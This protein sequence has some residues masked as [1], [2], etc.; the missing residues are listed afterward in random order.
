MN[1]RH[2][3]RRLGWGVT[4]QAVSSLSNVLVSLVVAHAL[5]PASFGAFSLAFVT[6]ALVL[7]ASRGLSTDPLLVRFSGAAD[8]RWRQAVAAATATATLV[9]TGCGVLGVAVGL[10]LPGQLGQ[11][12]LALG[13]GLPLLM[14]EDS[15][16]FAFFAVGRGLQALVLD[17]VWT[18][19]AI[20][21][22]A[23]LVVTHTEGVTSCLLVF[24]GS[25]A[26]SAGLGVLL[27]G[28]RP[29]PSLIVA[30]VS[31]HQRLGGRYLVENL[32]VGGSRQLRTMTV[33]G[34]AGLGAVG[35]VRAAEI[36]MGPFLV[37]LMG[38]AQVAVPEASRVVAEA[39][40]RLRAFCL[41]IGGSQAVV[42]LC[43]GLAMMVVLPYGGGRLLLGDLWPSVH[44]LLLP[45]TL[46]VVLG[47]LSSGATSGLRALGASPRS[48]R[49]QLIASA[50]Y[51]A[52]GA[53]GAF[54]GGA[55]GSAW[56]WTAGTL[57]AVA[58]WWHELGRACAEHAPDQDADPSRMLE[59]A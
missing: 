47:C 31:G 25:S 42:A 38:I 4:D 40:R 26:V 58:V 39:P 57:I 43:W 12:F 55:K 50:L 52:G 9:G 27:S 44:P 35:V 30:W 21:G 2:L 48:L 37:V 17:L 11:A 36:L 46:G 41:L 20:G 18:V 24:G 51:V 13:V 56:G 49:A 3:V 23:A 14:L 34:V 7:N 1:F 5:S 8:A 54:L 28:V 29:R 10:L 59:V 32:A 22:L 15:W 53:G 6:Y 16:R 33:G 45:I 19:L